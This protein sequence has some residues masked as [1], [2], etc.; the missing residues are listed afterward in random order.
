MMLRFSL[1]FPKEAER[2]E[3]AVQKV[4]AQGLRTADIYTE[5]TQK[6]S[7]AQMG[8]AVVKALG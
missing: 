6:V 5:G 7:T 8:D 2:I 3:T 1:N 4:L